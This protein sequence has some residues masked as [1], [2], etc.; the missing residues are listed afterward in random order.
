MQKLTKQDFATIKKAIIDFN[1]L[2][3]PEQVILKTQIDDIWWKLYNEYATLCKQDSNW[4]KM[5]DYIKDYELVTNFN[6]KEHFRKYAGSFNFEDPEFK[7]QIFEYDPEL[8]MQSIR[9]Y[10]DINTYKQNMNE[11]I[12]KLHH[13][14]LVFNKGAKLRKLRNQLRD[15]EELAENYAKLKNQEALK[16]DYLLNRT[17]T[18]ETYKAEI[19]KLSEQY[20][21]AVITKEL[22]NSPGIACYEHD[23]YISNNGYYADSSILNEVCNN[24]RHQA[25]NMIVTAHE[26]KHE[27]KGNDDLII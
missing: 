12:N 16:D 10:K 15:Q 4:I 26:A 17:Q 1:S 14:K 21:N 25:M 18:Y 20:A 24:I 13:K 19:Q 3:E 11:R 22:K 2:D 27:S 6:M 8:H 5:Y 9:A 7:N 23:A